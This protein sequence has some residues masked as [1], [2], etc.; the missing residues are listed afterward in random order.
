VHHNSLENLRVKKYNQSQWQYEISKKGV[1]TIGFMVPIICQKVI[2][3][4]E[5]KSLCKKNLENPY[6]IIQ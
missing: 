5:E 1:Q 2:A 3:A 6:E 4:S